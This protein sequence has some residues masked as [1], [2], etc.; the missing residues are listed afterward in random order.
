MA[1][2]SASHRWTGSLDRYAICVTSLDEIVGTG[3]TVAFVK[4]GRTYSPDTEDPL[5]QLML[6]M[7]SAFAEFE[8]SLIRKRQAEG[9]RIAKAEG[10]YTGRSSK[11]RENQIADARTLIS[12]GVPK[13]EVARPVRSRPIHPVSR[14]ERPI[15]V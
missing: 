6:H 3:A 14:I 9:I 12:T 13:A 8:R 1:T 15:D 4:E 11:L 10:K 5:S 7:L 2:W